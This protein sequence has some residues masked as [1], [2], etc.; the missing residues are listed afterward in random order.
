MKLAGDNQNVWKSLPFLR[1]YN[2]G[3]AL[4]LG[5]HVVVVGAGNTAMDCARA[6]LRVPGVEKATI[7]YRR[8]L[9]EM[10]AWREEYEEALHDGVEFRFL[11]NPER[12]DADGTLTLRVM[13]LGEPD[14]KGRRRPV[15]TNETVTLLVDS[16]ITAIGEQQDTE[17]LNAMGVPLDKN[18]WPDVDHNGETRLT[19]V[20]M[21]GDVQRGPSSI[22][23]AVGTARRATDA[24]LSRENIRSHQND[25]YW[26]NVNPAEIYQRKG[27]IS[28]TLVNSDDRDAFVAQ[29]AARCLECNYVCSKCV[30]VCPN[31]A[32]VS[33]AVPGFQNR[34]QRCTSTLTV[35][36]AATALSSVRGTVNRTKTKSPS[37]AWRKDFD[38]SSNPG[39]LVEDCRV[40]VRLNN[41]SWVLN[42]DS[43][44]QF[45]NVPPELNDMCRII[46]H[47]HQHHHYLLGRVEV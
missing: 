42:I 4:K 29:E 37:S 12:F 13:S 47:V 28:I 30:D 23:A 25:K 40:R 43:K 7:V 33:I 17:A 2:K 41:Q 19:D 31:R 38:N 39:F 8:S 26:N 22:V 10:P 5:K 20:F 11:N 35:T 21:I 16:L 18:G 36:N 9:Q 32:N 27:D 3:T 15:E 24:I 46:S 1:E 34:F 45:N 6:A 14:E 44:G